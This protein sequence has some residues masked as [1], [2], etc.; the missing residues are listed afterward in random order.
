MTIFDY[1]EIFEILKIFIIDLEDWELKPWRDG[2]V[3]DSKV[4]L[5]LC[6]RKR[7]VPVLFVVIDVIDPNSSLVLV[8]EPKDMFI[9]TFM[10]SQQ[11]K[12][13]VKYF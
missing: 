10:I 6:E 12:H 3:I 1:I 7:P 4:I 13:L 2:G 11:S 8:D 5:R 9:S